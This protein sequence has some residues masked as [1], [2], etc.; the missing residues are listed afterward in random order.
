MYLATHHSYI[1]AN[2]SLWVGSCSSIVGML[3]LLLLTFSSVLK[4]S[5]EIRACSSKPGMLLLLPGLSS[6][7]ILS[8]EVCGCSLWILGML[9]LLLPGLSSLVK[10]S[11]EVGISWSVLKMLLYPFPRLDDLEER[12]LLRLT[13]L[14][15]KF[16]ESG[17]DGW[18]VRFSES[19]WD[20]WDG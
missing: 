14:L 8:V 16:S 2:Y 18:V 10:M 15:A 19:G 1:D 11:L 13:C 6:L 7:V 5:V 4:L 3:L 9:L 12:P 17:C 20:G